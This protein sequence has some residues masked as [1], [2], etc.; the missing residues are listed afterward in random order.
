M[1]TTKSANLTSLFYKKS[2]TRTCTEI[3]NEIAEAI[4]NL[5][6]FDYAESYNKLPTGDNISLN[7]IYLVPNRDSTVAT[8]R[9]DFY[10]YYNNHW[11]QL[12]ALP[13]DIEDYVAIDDIIDNLTSTATEKPLSAK[14][15]A[16]LKALI[17]TKVDKVNGKGLSTNDFT[18]AYKTKL[19]NL[20]NNLNSKVDK[21][22]G[23]GLSEADY[24]NAE[25]TKLAGI[26]TGATRVIVDDHLDN[27]ST[28]PVQNKVIVEEYYDKDEI[29][30]LLNN[31]QT[32]S[33]KLLSV[34]IDETTGDLIVD[35]DGFVYYTQDEVDEGFTVDVVK[36]TTPDAGYLTTY[37]IK[38]GNKTVGTKI[39]IPKDFLIKSASIKTST[40]DNTPISGI[41]KG[42]KYFDF[43][44]NTK[45][46]SAT[47][48]H[49]YLNAKDLVDSY[50][51]DETTLTMDNTNVF[52][53]KNVPVEKI[54]GILP[55]NQVTHQD[56]TG[57]VDKVT[58]KGLSTNDFTATYKSK[59][60]N[61]DS[62]LNNK[63]DKVTGKGLSETDYTNAE[64]TKL[65]GIETGANKTVVD[66]S[67]ISN[68]TNPVQSKVVKSALDEKADASDLASV[69][70][71]G[72]YIDLKNKPS[73]MTP[74]AHNHAIEEVTN[75]QSTLNNK[76]NSS[77]YA[78]VTLEVTFED[79]TTASYDLV[80]YKRS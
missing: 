49:L 66:S 43:V 18:S 33:G 61:L 74:S 59:L 41:M 7:K 10:M 36:Q 12:D 23:K 22:T 42:D 73:S 68:S 8:N 71:S 30:D 54:T 67:F 70:T 11:E 24:T 9:F 56:I 21:I 40:A 28:N 55:A 1:A 76:M 53:I 38:Q 15:G 37:V 77:D 13:F 17:D 39:N 52:S 64:K 44:L 69:A 32:A 19:D 14:Q 3:T 16:V 46:G 35:D 47:D 34:S 27:T 72:S 57:K 20:D 78:T 2:E 80:Y 62:N 48:E 45:D 4:R 26:A 31:I 65:E 25:K 51:A 29:L 58:G 6:I 60:D 75:L 63:V 5:S 79:D 50:S